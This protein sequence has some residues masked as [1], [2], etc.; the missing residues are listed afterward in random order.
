MANR[1]AV[2]GA[3]VFGLTAAIELARRG[4]SVSVHEQGQIPNPLA[5]STDI[6]K[7]VRME[8]GKD[9]A[10]MQLAARARE[11]WLA[12]N[13]G[14]AQKGLRPL[15]HD[16]GVL[17]CSRN[18]MADSGFE[19]DSYRLLLENDFRPTR[20]T[21][22][23]IS[24]K[25]PSWRN[26]Y[27]KDG[28]YNPCG[29]WVESGEVLRRLVDA[30]RETGV[31]IDEENR[32][33]QVLRDRETVRGLVTER[34]DVDADVVVLACGSWSPRLASLGESIRATGHPVFHFKPANPEMF[35]ADRFPTFT[36]DVSKT[37]YYGFPVNHDGLVKIG[38]HTLGVPVDPDDPVTVPAEQF[39]LVRSFLKEALPELAD[40]ELVY[41]R[42]CPYADTPDEDFWIDEDPDCRGLFVAAGGSGHGF[43]FAPVLG[44]LIADI[45]E[46]RPHA[47]AEKFRWR[48]DLEVGAGKE[49]A[50]CRESL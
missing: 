13:D 6:S 5:A 48:A 49:A 26:T 37:G 22:K 47:L 1:V 46:G 4:N 25:Y 29:G 36:A 44:A 38:K 15:Y 42:M 32:V 24:E 34:R 33:T 28:F 23:N 50:R 30:A 40:A 8:Y 12:W 16:T 19:I 21:G 39:D 11:G 18:A 17:M 35:A 41:S 2:A 27:F 3:G 10:Y 14:W 45:V 31:L 7:I 9:V 43:K 20:L